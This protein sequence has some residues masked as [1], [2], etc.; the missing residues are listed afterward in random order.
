MATP[1]PTTPVHSPPTTGLPPD[2]RP[3]PRLTAEGAEPAPSDTNPH[4]AGSVRAAHHCTECRSTDLE[5]RS[6]TYTTI[7]ICTCGHAWSVAHNG[8]RVTR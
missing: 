5:S 2:G 6:Y 4:G 3:A 1:E 8:E 7:L